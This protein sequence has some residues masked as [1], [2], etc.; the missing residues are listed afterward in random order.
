[1][2]VGLTRQRPIAL[3]LSLAPR[4]RS[5]P[6]A[7]HTM[8]S[9]MVKNLVLLLGAFF[10]LSMTAVT[11]YSGSRGSLQGAHQDDVGSGGRDARATAELIHQ[12]RTRVQAVESDR[13]RMVTQIKELKE[14]YAGESVNCQEAADDRLR[15]ELNKLR[16]KLATGEKGEAG[17]IT[18]L[19]AEIVSLKSKL[20]AA[21]GMQTA[22]EKKALEPNGGFATQQ[23]IQFPGETAPSVTIEI[24]LHTAVMNPLGPENHVIGIEASLA[25]I[26]QHWN[27]LA[28]SNVLLLNAAMFDT[29]SLGTNGVIF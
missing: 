4:V 29:D 7:G 18:K 10:V 1:M 2:P 25:T 11:W 17:E 15:D 5:P 12:L 28:K 20:A 23:L 8:A 14:K 26:H 9:P 22:R 16:G 13:A 19:Q 27:A 6:M 21:P 24:G 3:C